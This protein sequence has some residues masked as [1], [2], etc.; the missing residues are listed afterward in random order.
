MAEN[1]FDL[2]AYLR[3]IGYQGPREAT[4]QVLRAVV[5]AQAA[6][7]AFENIDVLLRRGIRID[8]PA[9]QDKLVRRGRGGYCFEQNTL[10][11]A[12]L[13][14]LGFRLQTLAARVIRGLP[15]SAPASPRAHKLL[16]VELPEGPYLADVGF[17][18]LT[19]TAPLALRL[20]EEQ[21]TSHEIFRLMPRGGEV[22]L[23]ARL[24]SAWD[25]LYHF[26]PEPVPPVDYEMANWF[27]AAFPGSPFVANLIVALPGAGRRSTLYNRRFAVRATD[28]TVSR[29]VLTGTDEYR[30]ILVGHFGLSLAAEEIAG[31]TDAMAG[32]AADE[33]V[34]CF[35]A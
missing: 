19:P 5:A 8:V 29:R 14:A 11:E 7:M 26:S 25:S 21:P 31:I 34:L 18:N 4:P 22:V 30:E 2:D 16:R 3:R 9:V 27:C 13:E 1:G 23:Q 32:H 17:G 10:L 20:E 35:F 24:G 33:E 28:G 6:A 15:D 12:A